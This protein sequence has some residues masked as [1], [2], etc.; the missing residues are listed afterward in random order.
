MGRG[1]QFPPACYICW[2]AIIESEERAHNENYPGR[3]LGG[4]VTGGSLR[5]AHGN[6]YYGGNAVN[7]AYPHAPPVP[8]AGSVM[9]AAH[10]YPRA[11]SDTAPDGYAFAY[12]AA[13]IYRIGMK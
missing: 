3:I 11:G 2:V 7:P 1:K 6:P 12:G 4:G 13:G 5:R 8:A 10:A 9:G